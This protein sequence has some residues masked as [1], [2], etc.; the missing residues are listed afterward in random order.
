[1]LGKRSALLAQPSWSSRG[2]AT[3]AISSAGGTAGSI[4]D[5]VP[6]GFD[7]DSMRVACSVVVR[8]GKV[9]VSAYLV[10][11]ILVRLGTPESKMNTAS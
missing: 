3:A 2:C 7:R 11:L 4:Y 1:M 9:W 8:E 5:G 6:Q 10:C